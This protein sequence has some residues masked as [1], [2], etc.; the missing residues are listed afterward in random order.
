MNQ[1][2]ELVFLLEEPSAKI[3]LQNVRERLPH[4]NI[5][6][7]YIVFE[8][9]GDLDKN[10]ANRVKNYCNN[11]ARF[12]I[13]R[14]KDSADCKKLK[15]EMLNKIFSIKGK[16]IKIRIACH[17]LESFYL[18]D[19]KAVETGMGISK[20]S[21]MQNNRKYREPDQLANAK[22]EL[23]NITHKRYQSVSSSRHI[24]P[25]LS[26]DGTNKSDSFNILVQ[27]INEQIA[28]F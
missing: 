9:K 28:S 5:Q 20:L 6:F 3:M 13:L 7:N 10:F 11:N 4:N 18:G 22:Q 17:E 24:A 8:G 26:L 14:D 21:A 19:L 23:Q 16:N 25:Y 15:Q 12:I 27:C 1:E 2:K